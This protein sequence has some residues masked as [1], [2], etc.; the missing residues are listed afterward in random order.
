VDHIGGI[1][2]TFCC[3]NAAAEDYAKVGLM[4]MNNGMVGSTRVLDLNWIKRMS[5]SVEQIDDFGYSAFMWHPFPQID[6]MD[7]LHGQ[8]IFIDRASRTVIVKLSD[9]PTDMNLTKQTSQ[10]MMDV[11][12]N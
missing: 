12:K 8:Y 3:F 1:E 5:T 11:A 4:V 10:V 7:G 6:M 9:V 2:K